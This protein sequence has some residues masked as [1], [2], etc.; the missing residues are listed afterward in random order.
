MISSISNRKTPKDYDGDG[1]IGIDDLKKTLIALTKN[2]LTQDEVDIVCGKVLEESDDDNDGQISFMEFQHVVSRSPDFM[3]LD[4]HLFNV[5]RSIN[6]A[7]FL[8]ELNPVQLTSSNF[9]M[10][11]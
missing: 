9:R 7:L 2:R 6:I 1:F 4:M 8:T 3:R 5:I 10:R 11:V